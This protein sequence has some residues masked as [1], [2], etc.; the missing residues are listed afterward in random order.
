MADTPHSFRHVPS[1]HIHTYSH[2]RMAPSCVIRH[3]LHCTFATPSTDLPE[4]TFSN[5]PHKHTQNNHSRRCHT[6]TTSHAQPPHLPH[7]AVGRRRD[8]S[9]T[10]HTHTPSTP[11]RPR[12]WKAR[13]SKASRESSCPATPTH[14]FATTQI[15]PSCNRKPAAPKQ[16]S[17][18]KPCLS[19]P[20]PVCGPSIRCSTT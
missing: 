1:M 17:Q 14:L 16:K 3:T 15:I 9:S 7:T 5:T 10:P 11:Q 2:T 4:A 13:N 18:A 6:S 8:G 20:C 19:F 12:F